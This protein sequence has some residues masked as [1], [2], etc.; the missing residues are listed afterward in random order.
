MAWL[1]FTADMDWKP[2]PGTTI[3][4]KAGTVL[5]VPSAAARAA[6]TA[7]KA[8]RLRAPR[9]GEVAELANAEGTEDN[10]PM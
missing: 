6:V 7:G 8:V 4:Y 2:T 3:A 5:N 1:R 9:K 10:A